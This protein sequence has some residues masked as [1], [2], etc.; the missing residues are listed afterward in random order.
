[1]HRAQQ[2][3]GARLRRPAVAAAETE[4]APRGRRQTGER[5]GGPQDG[6]ENLK[7]MSIRGSKEWRKGKA[8]GEINSV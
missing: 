5:T 7:K 6:G 8:E 2:L 4:E 3:L 1:M